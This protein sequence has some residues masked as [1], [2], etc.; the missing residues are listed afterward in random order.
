MVAETPSRGSRLFPEICINL[1]MGSR[2]SQIFLPPAVQISA[3]S[4]VVAVVIAVCY[5]AASCISYGR[6][7]G[8]KEAA[9]VRAE[10]ANAA[11]KADPWWAQAHIV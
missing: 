6:A 7:V 8:D 11:D 4:A 1:R 10:T 3:A 2:H 9:V 5:F